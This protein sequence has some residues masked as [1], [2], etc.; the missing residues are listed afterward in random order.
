[1][2]FSGRVALVTGAARGLGYASASI[3]AR[4]GAN[5]VVNDL[6]LDAATKAAESL[7]VTTGASHLGMAGDVSCE[8]DV[9]AAI[10][11]VYDRFGRLDVVVN[12]AGVF[13]EFIPT[14][15]QTTAYWQRLI[16]VH[17]TGT[18]LVSKFAAA[19]MIEARCGVVINTSSIGGVLGLPVRTG[20]SAAKAGVS[21]MT[22]VLAC[23]WA[24]Y[25]LRVNAVAPGYIDTQSPDSPASKGHLDVDRIRRRIPSGLIG[26]PE[27]VA[28]AVLFLA[29][30]RS[31]YING[32]TL[33]VDG[34]YMAFG[35]PTN[36]YPW[37]RLPEP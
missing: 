13:E 34:G 12:N 14:V 28:E 18:Y 5:V 27:H 23:E 37:E 35:A 24:P 25:G 7:Q 36:A 32:V 4:N 26:K 31:A 10:E 11:R 30:D 1:M 20:Y 33:A 2:E 9:S 3:L 16:D 19:R 15:E 29:S 21:M 17:L 22:R 8:S 6:S